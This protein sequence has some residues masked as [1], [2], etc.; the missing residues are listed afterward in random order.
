MDRLL[1]SPLQYIEKNRIKSGSISTPMVAIVTST[2]E[3]S[4]KDVKV[5][6]S[7]H[8]CYF[9]PGFQSEIEVMKL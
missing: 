3:R 9:F 5:N 2:R 7:F 6:S 8:L 1:A 4:I